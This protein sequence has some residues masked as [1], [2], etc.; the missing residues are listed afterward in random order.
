M[1]GGVAV[2]F[3]GG[4][5]VGGWGA[6]V[7]ALSV[8][9]SAVSRSGWCV[10]CLFYFV[11]TSFLFPVVLVIFIIS[12]VCCVCV[13]LGRQRVGGG[14]LGVLAGSSHC[15]HCWCAL[16]PKYSFG[17]LV[18]SG[19]SGWS[20]YMF[21]SGSC[22][23]NLVHFVSDRVSLCSWLSVLRLQGAVSLIS[24]RVWVSGNLGNRGKVP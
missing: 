11:L 18:Q 8:L 12:R 4:V 2:Q 20:R 7:G 17:G 15:F 3:E 9:P 13:L 16:A 24:V 14:R 23:A 10:G 22:Q 21:T 6:A 1:T 5:C 19:L